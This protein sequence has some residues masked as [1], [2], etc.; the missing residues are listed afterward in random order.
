M[1]DRQEQRRE[2]YRKFRI[3]W[4]AGVEKREG[5]KVVRKQL[6]RLEEPG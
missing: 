5:S 6:R 4:M 2:L 1:S 3:V